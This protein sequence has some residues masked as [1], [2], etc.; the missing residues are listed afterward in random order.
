MDNNENIEERLEKLEK[1]NKKSVGVIIALVIIVLILVALLLMAKTN[2]LETIGLTNKQS[3]SAPEVVDKDDKDKEE[4]T[5]KEPEKIVGEQVNNT[6][7]EVLK[8]L[9][10]VGGCG[11]LDFFVSTTKI[12][13]ND[14][15]GSTAFLLVYHNE[16]FPLYKTSYEM[17]N[18]IPV[19][20]V[21]QKATKYLGKNYS[22]VPENPK[23]CNNYKYDAASS[24]YVRIQSGCGG[25]CGP[26][27]YS[28]NSAYIQGDYLYASVTNSGTNYL[29]TFVNEDG[30]YI[31]VSSEP[32]AY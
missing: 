31:F 20:D 15:S 29:F 17:P 1:S 19:S 32:V 24:S 12:T 4:E 11:L 27:T 21:A 25:A 7:N 22:F 13:A 14:I 30:N 5:T 26:D 10:K 2:I 6:A 9:S 18:S 23:A 28:V 3:N 16:Y 8:K